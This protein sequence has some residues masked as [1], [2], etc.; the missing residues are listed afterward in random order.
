MLASLLI[1][2]AFLAFLAIIDPQPGDS[3]I[4]RAKSISQHMQVG[5]GASVGN[6]PSF[7]TKRQK[8]EIQHT[9][10]E[11]IRI[12]LETTVESVDLPNETLE[13]RVTRLNGI[14]SGLGGNAP[15][16]RIV[17]GDAGVPPT[18][19]LP[20]LKLRNVP[21][22][23]FLRYVSDW[24]RGPLVVGKGYVEFTNIYDPRYEEATRAGDG[25]PYFE[26]RTE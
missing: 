18:E 21:L 9:R 10:D 7:K 26:F 6:A 22:W 11:T 5:E 23:T 20:E 1:V 2:L 19:T 14:V 17:L 3:D 24:T 16:V 4:L 13:D 12:L 8:R 15:R 25:D